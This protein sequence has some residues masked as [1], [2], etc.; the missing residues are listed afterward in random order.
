MPPGKNTKQ[1]LKEK[2]SDMEGGLCSE[3]MV[4]KN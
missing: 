1:A 4:P 3:T 2:Q